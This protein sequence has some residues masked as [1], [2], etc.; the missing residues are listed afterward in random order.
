MARLPARAAAVTAGPIVISV[1]ED[2]IVPRPG[3]RSSDTRHSGA[4]TFFFMLTKRSVPPARTLALPLWSA[5][6]R[7][8]ST[9]SAGRRKSNR[10]SSMSPLLSSAVAEPE[11][12]PWSYRQCHRSVTIDF[13]DVGYAPEITGFV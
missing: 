6:M 10:G 13:G 1:L 2:L 7:Q 9:R 5:S 12:G 11:P 3:R 4:S 8:A